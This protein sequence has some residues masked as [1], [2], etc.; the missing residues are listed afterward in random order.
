M[1]SNQDGQDSLLESIDSGDA[2]DQLLGYMHEGES[3]DEALE[4]LLFALPSFA[5]LECH[6]CGRELELKDDDWIA[7]RLRVEDTDYRRTDL[8]CG[9]SCLGK[10]INAIIKAPTTDGWSNHEQ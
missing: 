3:A 4:R 6:E 8:Y 1:S 9:L 7:W 5:H 2:H 10:S